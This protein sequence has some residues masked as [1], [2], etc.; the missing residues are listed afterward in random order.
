MT[1]PRRPREPAHPLDCHE[2]ALRLLAARPRSRRELRDRLL[3]A[4]FDADQVEEELGRLEAVGLVDDARFA[5]AVA[6][7]H[8]VRR[9]AGSRAVLAAL[10]A[11][12]VDRATAEAV[13]AEVAAAER[14]PGEE[15]RAR[16][17]ALARVERL[18]GLPPERAFERLVGFLVRRGHAAD[19]ARDAARS[20]LGLS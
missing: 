3:A 11:K 15:E 12:G 10:A 7:Q 2:R 17:L 1:G 19:T 9:G 13:L 20:A 8:L 5:R 18:R 16:A 14:V 4:G 6:E